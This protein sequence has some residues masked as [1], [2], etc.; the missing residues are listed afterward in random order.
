MGYDGLL[1]GMFCGHFY[2]TTG[3]EDQVSLLTKSDVFG[4]Q[5]VCSNMLTLDELFCAMAI[6]WLAC[7]CHFLFIE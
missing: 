3:L 4:C 1:C 5:C 6:T 7:V 2:F